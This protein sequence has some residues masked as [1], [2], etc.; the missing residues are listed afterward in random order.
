MKTGPQSA[1]QRV[2]DLF[3]DRFFFIVNRLFCTVA[4][5]IHPGAELIGE[6][7]IDLIRESL[8]QILNVRFG[9]KSIRL[10][11]LSMIADNCSSASVESITA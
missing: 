4:G 6:F 9:I 3:S 1:A 7:R 2:F 11:I 8:V 10:T 5:L